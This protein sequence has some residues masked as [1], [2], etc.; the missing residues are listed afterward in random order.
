MYIIY[1]EKIIKIHSDLYDELREIKKGNKKFISFSN[2][3]KDLL[4]NNKI[5]QKEEDS[6]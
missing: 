1:M 4:K 2:I 6:L 5:N 3:I